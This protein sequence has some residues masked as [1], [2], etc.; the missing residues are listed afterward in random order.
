M[1]ALLL[2]LAI[3]GPVSARILQDGDEIVEQP[4]A[5]HYAENLQETIERL[6]D[7]PK[8]SG[9]FDVCVNGDCAQFSKPAPAKQPDAATAVERI[10]SGL[11][12]A[13]G[14]HVEVGFT[15]RE[16]IIHSDGSSTQRDI[17]VTIAASTGSSGQGSMDAATSKAH[18]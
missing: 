11:M 17:T 14:G 10:A 13:T 18:K 1:K 12:R 8:V 6:Q 16:T 15:Y 3:S 5:G 2:L 7:D 9:T 4:K